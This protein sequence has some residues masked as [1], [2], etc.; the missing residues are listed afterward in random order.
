M[1]KRK[2]TEL[3][4]LDAASVEF[5]SSYGEKIDKDEERKLFEKLSEIDG[6]ADYLRTT[7]AHDV[8]RYFVAT[9]PMEQLLARGAFQR[10][11]YLRGLLKKTNTPKEPKEISKGMKVSRYA[12]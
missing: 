10:T 5:I 3:E 8:Q 4:I 6:F 12:K 11:L 1:T 2:L 7:M 9:T